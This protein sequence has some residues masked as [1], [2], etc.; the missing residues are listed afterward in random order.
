MGELHVGSVKVGEHIGAVR[1]GPGRQSVSSA[2]LAAA[3]DCAMLIDHAGRLLE[4]NRAAEQQ[5]GYQRLELLGMGLAELIAPPRQRERARHALSRCLASAEGGILDGPL[6]LIGIRS[7]GSEFPMKLTMTRVPGSEPPCVATYVR[8][9][10]ERRRTEQELTEALGRERAA[11][12]EAVVQGLRSKRLVAQLLST[13]ERERR[14]L[15]RSVH[16]GP[17]Q[18]LA[19]AQLALGRSARAGTQSISAA[20]DAV[21]DAIAQLRQGLVDLYPPALERQGL[22]AA[23]RDLTDKIGRRSGLRISLEIG[24]DTPGAHDQLIF[25]LV[26]ELLFNAERH[27][28]A[29]EVTIRVQRH[30]DEL[31]LE[32]EDDGIGVS[33]GRLEAAQDQGHIGLASSIERVEALRGSLSI[34][35]GGVRGTRVRATLPARRSTDR[36]RVRTAPRSPDA[37]HHG[38]ERRSITL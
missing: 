24:A 28:H 36:P 23:L 25:S 9:L 29:T 34:R 4:F 31:T 16:D 22:A 13:E 10:A 11:R 5:F 18:L 32:V 35:A 37:T 1:N 33:P 7:D 2:I 15:A 30:D 12:A 19:A 27:A 17:L 20:Q 8:D 14:R 26:R 3:F 6:E 38:L 21:S